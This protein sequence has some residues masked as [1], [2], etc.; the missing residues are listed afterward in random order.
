MILEFAADAGVGRDGS[1]AR[2]G[3]THKMYI[4]VHKM[5]ISF[6]LLE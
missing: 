4:D 6:G 5:S 1:V 3:I 2:F